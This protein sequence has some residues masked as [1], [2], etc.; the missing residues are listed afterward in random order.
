M[1]EAEV[2]YLRLKHAE[3]LSDTS[4]HVLNQDEIDHFEGL[5][6]YPFSPD[7]Q[8]EAV[9]IKDKG[10]KFEMLTSTDRKPW[11]R[12]YGFI[13]FEV[14]GIKCKLEVYQNLALK[15]RKEYKNYLFIPFTDLTCGETTYGAGRYIDTEIPEGNTLLI[16]F[17]LAYNP[18]C[19]YSHRYSCPIPPEFNHLKTL[20]EAGEKTPLGH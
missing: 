5:D 10:K 16:D 2:E 20:I 7:Y 14:N 15:K 11:Y 1:S 9:L 12:R 18:Y 13:E 4:N 17:N 6:Y 19:A 3:E 8:I